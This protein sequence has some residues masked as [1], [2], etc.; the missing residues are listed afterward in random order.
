MSE[1]LETLKYVF[2]V[3]GETEQWYLVWLRDQINLCETRKYNVAIDAKVQQSPRKFYKNV[4]VKTTPKAT[5]IC[6]VES[7]EPF[8]V[9]KFMNVLTEMREGS[10]QKGIQYNLG[11]SN[12]SF[13]LWIVLHKK[14]CNGALA[15][16]KQY[17]KPINQAFGESFETLDHFKHEN[18]FKRCLSKISLANVKQAI[19][20][21]EKITSSNEKNGKKQKEYKGYSYYRD[22]PSLS[23][24]EAIKEILD[25]CGV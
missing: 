1:R 6:D 22:N 15:D 13:E 21:A 17:L 10:D 9:A 18:N 19:E 12:Y 24:H 8:H 2:T 4:N 3:E 25:E 7:N 20:R 16:R 5:H 14:T 23:I 11:Y